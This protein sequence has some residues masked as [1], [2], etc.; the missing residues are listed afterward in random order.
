MSL[1]F[2]SVFPSDLVSH[3]E[4]VQKETNVLLLINELM[5]IDKHTSSRIIF[6][7]GALLLAIP[8]P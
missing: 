4:K 2:F 3:T 1:V 5:Q 6:R 7:T 8:P